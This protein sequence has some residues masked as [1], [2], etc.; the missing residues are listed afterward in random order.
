MFEAARWPVASGFY[1]LSHDDRDGRPR[2]HQRAVG[3][4]LAAGLLAELLYLNRIGIG[5]G[6]VWVVDRTPPDD[7]VAHLAL[8]HLI[9][10]PQHVLVRTWLDF[11]AMNAGEQVAGRLVLDGCL[12]KDTIR[13]MF[14]SSVVYLPVDMNAFAAVMARLST[15][16]RRIGPLSPVDVCLAGLSVATG[17]DAFVLD[18][19]SRDAW[20][21][22]RYVVEHVPPALHDLF[23]QTTAAVGGSVLS[24]R[25]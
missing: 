4:G 6:Q 5:R 13:R 10:E 15:Q 3:L 18:G 1:M 21:Y 17:L 14:R 20:R 11:L 19:A 8:A 2:L 9:S 23:A 24:H 7:A 25:I 22:L 16:L 12:R